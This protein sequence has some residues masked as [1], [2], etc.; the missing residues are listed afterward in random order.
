MEQKIKLKCPRCG[1]NLSVKSQPGLESKNLTCPVCKESSAFSSY[2]V[3]TPQNK[4][5]GEHTIIKEDFKNFSHTPEV[6]GELKILGSTQRIRLKK[7]QNIIGRKASNSSA[8]CQILTDN[9]RI[10]R[11]HLRIEVKNVEGKGLVHLLSLYKEQVNPTSINGENLVW[12]DSLVLRSG[13]VISLADLR[14]KFE[15]PDDEKTEMI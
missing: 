14:L 7:G 4:P 9:R 5:D 10:S 15:I 11:E 2:R 8:D 6:V 1:A 12:G 3:I 13:D